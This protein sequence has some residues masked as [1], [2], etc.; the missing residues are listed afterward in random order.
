MPLLPKEKVCTY[1]GVESGDLKR[2]RPWLS[3]IVDPR[4][5]GEDEMCVLGSVGHVLADL[6]WPPQKELKFVCVAYPPFLQAFGWIPAVGM[7]SWPPPGLRGHPVGLSSPRVFLLICRN[8]C[9][10][11]L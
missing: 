4:L 3:D 11:W 6:A 5:P 2:T 9:Q 10:W 7:W 1:R 8:P